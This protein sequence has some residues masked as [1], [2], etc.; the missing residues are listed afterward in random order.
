[1]ATRALGP[2]DD[3]VTGRGELGSV[4]GLR[5][6]A[7]A[8]RPVVL[9]ALRLSASVL[10]EAIGGGLLEDALVG[11]VGGSGYTFYLD[12]R[13]V[14]KGLPGNERAAVLTARLGHV[15]RSWLADLRGDVLVLGCDGHLDDVSVPRFVVDAAVRS[16]LLVQ[17]VGAAR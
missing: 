15:N 12:E 14:A 4:L 11:E 1:M 3:G 17:G 9:S 8:G 10:S 5:I 16:G 6:P 13:R 7:D 2:R